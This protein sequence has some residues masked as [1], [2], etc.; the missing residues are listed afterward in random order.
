MYD[1]LQISREQKVWIVCKWKL[2]SYTAAWTSLSSSHYQLYTHLIMYP[3]CLL[4]LVLTLFHFDYI[5]EIIIKLYV[6][7]P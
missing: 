5:F 2:L 1:I 3:L 4:F 7:C 6:S